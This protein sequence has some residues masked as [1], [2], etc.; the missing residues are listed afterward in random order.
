MLGLEYFLLV[1]GILVRY[2]SELL[3]LNVDNPLFMACVM[4]IMAVRDLCALMIAVMEMLVANAGVPRLWD[5]LYSER[6]APRM[7]IDVVHE[8][9]VVE[10]EDDHVEEAVVGEETAGLDSLILPNEDFAVNVSVNQIVDRDI[11]EPRVRGVNRFSRVRR[12]V[13]ECNRLATRYRSECF[14][15]CM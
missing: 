4:V 3:T 15:S 12:R 7:N 2:A 10:V 6:D 11:E 1:V 13:Q 8:P 14:G 5:L 9:E